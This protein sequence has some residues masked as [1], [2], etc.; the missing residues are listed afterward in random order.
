MPAFHVLHAERELGH[1]P[2]FVCPRRVAFVCI[3]E[4]LG[5]LVPEAGE[6]L[7]ELGVV[8]LLSLLTLFVLVILR[9]GVIESRPWIVGRDKPAAD[10]EGGYGCD[11]SEAR[12]ATMRP[13]VK[14]HGSWSTKRGGMAGR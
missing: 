5:V 8:P 12:S 2:Q 9:L 10:P 14:L 6:V 7:I 4:L 13:G 11:R 1:A 3:S